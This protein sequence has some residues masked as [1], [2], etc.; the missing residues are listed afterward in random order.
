MYVFGSST[1]V[2]RDDT[3]SMNLKKNFKLGSISCL[4]DGEISTGFHIAV[5]GPYI[6]YNVLLRDLER[7]PTTSF[8]LH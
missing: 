1:S 7:H 4:V 5:L 3:I 6:P 8:E 2:T